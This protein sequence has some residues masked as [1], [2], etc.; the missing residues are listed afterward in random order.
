MMTPTE[1]APVDSRRLCVCQAMNVGSV[2]MLSGPRVLSRR[3]GPADPAS[4]QLVMLCKDSII[5]AC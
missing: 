5:C 4:P 1:M 2:T 3:A